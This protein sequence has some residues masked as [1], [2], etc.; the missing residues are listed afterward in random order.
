MIEPGR[1]SAHGMIARSSRVVNTI[2]SSASVRTVATWV[3]AAI[4]TLSGC[5][6]VSQKVTAARAATGGKRRTPR[7]SR[8]LT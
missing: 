8:N 1:A 3:P 5:G 6:A 2:A 7:S 4:R